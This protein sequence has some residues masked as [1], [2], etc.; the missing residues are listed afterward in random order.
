[1][2]RFPDPEQSKMSKVLQH[3]L[4]DRLQQSLVL[5]RAGSKSPSCTRMPDEDTYERTPS[6]GSAYW[7]PLC[8]LTAALYVTHVYLGSADGQRP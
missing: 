4:K 8:V 1:M 3:P 7:C 6:P 2:D 5:S